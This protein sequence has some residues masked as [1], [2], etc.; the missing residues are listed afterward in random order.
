MTYTLLT[1]DSISPKAMAPALAGCLGIAVGDVD[2]ADPDGDPDVRNWDAL[3]SCEHRAVFG[4]VS[5]SLDIYADER[6]A[7]RTPESD[8][9]VRFARAAGTTVLFPASEAPPS[10]F[11]V[12]TQEGLLTRARLELSD[13]EPHRYAVTAVEAPVAQLPRATVTRFAEIVREQRPPTPLVD[14]FWASVERMRESASEPARSAFDDSTRSPLWAARDSLVAWERV[15]VQMESGWA[16]SGWYPAELYRERL[17][18]RDVLA[19]IGSLL[20]GE[21]SVLLDETLERLDGRFAAATEDD[22]MGLLRKELSVDTSLDQAPTGWWWH[23][24]PAPVPWEQ[25]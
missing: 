19:D 6:V 17:Q 2:V 22:E 14:S 18:A 21:V 11:W 12:A 13:G 23:R 1:V 20:P 3:V 8:L 15:I 16:P 5:W 9:A 4:D 24:R 10:A 25:T 7:R